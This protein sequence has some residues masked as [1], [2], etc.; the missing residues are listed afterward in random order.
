MERFKKFITSR[1]F[2]QT[3]ASIAIIAAISCAFFSPD[4]MEGNVLN[5]HDSLQ[6]MANSAEIN[7]F[8]AQTGETSFWTN[9]LFSG[10]PAYQI[11][12]SYSSGKLFDWLNTLFGLGLPAPANY[13]AM[14]M[15]GMLILLLAMKVRPWLALTGAVAW[16][17]SSY[18]VI[19]IGAGHLWK[20]ITLAYVP[21]TIAGLYLIYNGRRLLGAAL[22]AL[23]M[24]L[25]IGGNHVQMT[26]YFAFV[27]AALV[28]AFGIQ[29]LRSRQIA[30]WGINTAI[31][32][33]A[34]LLAV[35]ANAPN[36]WH[37]YNYS[38]HT[39]RG[40]HS[41][42]TSETNP[43][44]STSG[45][46]RDYIT[47]YSYGKAET[48]SLLIPNIQGGASAK[49]VE[50]H[51]SRLTLADT[52]Q[53]KQLM[54]SNQMM[55]LLQIFSQY[56]GGAE[57][58][59]GPVYVGAI[60]V[61][62]FIFGAIV[63]RGPVK[64][65]LVVMTLLSIFL[66]WGRN[67][68]WFTDLFIDY[69][70]M[71]SRFRTVESILVIAEFCMP[72]LAILGLR[73]FLKADNRKAMLKP[74]AISFGICAAFCI[75][76]F[77]AP[78]MF[79]DTIM[80]EGDQMA[81]QQFVAYGALP[82]EFNMQQYPQVLSAMESIRASLVETDALRSLMYLLV[83]AMVMYFYVSG[84]LKKKTW[85]VAIIGVA[86]LA[87]LYTADK[88]YLNHDSFVKP[89][90]QTFTPSPADLA[91][92]QDPEPDYRV[93]NVREFQSPNPSYFHKSIGGYHAAKLTRYQDLIDRHLQ[94]TAS[95]NV[96][97]LLALR[98]DS[99]LMANFSPEE[100]RKPLADLRVLDMLN[101]KYV[102]IDPSQQPLLNR[103]ALGN[104]WF[105]DSLMLV[106]S[107]NDEMDALTLINPAT[108]AVADRKFADAL[109]TPAPDS[110]TSITL[111][112]YAPNRLT[113][114]AS[115]AKAGIAVFSEIYYPEGWTATIDGKPAEIARVNYVLR[116]LQIP[117]GNHKVEFTFKPA[118]V[119]T[120]N[121]VATASI[122]LIYLLLIGG[123]LC[124]PRKDR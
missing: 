121:T 87:D 19:I 18:F 31:L 50:G 43:E 65:A 47:M 101:T 55:N 109:G 58:T 110:T 24:A 51:M 75:A 12:P 122:I 83:A 106:D 114:D 56:Y 35:A 94:Y 98:E 79:G 104:A 81:V 11:T 2:L 64:W 59:N 108:T 119:K 118:S 76:A 67:M 16:G 40:A 41:E 27:M 3:L 28:I 92:L 20:F 37:T 111:T 8:E 34:M 38:K 61:A 49:P 120:T 89:L 15:I 68:L 62:L 7:A 14:M 91:I 4:A 100:L 17:L 97:Q 66:A 77:F 99:A 107:P 105:V 60:I 85:V 123:I 113:Y 95:P 74:L 26:Y 103:R 30:R 21:P 57:G 46:D 71:Y 5:Q 44:N 63:V 48:L 33:G 84:L 53:G 69:V 36:L 25:Q 73:E 29:A 45:L 9:S 32:A 116:A 117:A 54:Q 82:P 86:I 112:S 124:T 39:M 88:R 10:M 1:G 13:L 52:E 23:F 102:I 22:A 42:L 80:S 78:S 72:L 96:A 90:A 93:L 6:G 115:A 70:P